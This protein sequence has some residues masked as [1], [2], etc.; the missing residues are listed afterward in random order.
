MA[1]ALA[2]GWG[3]GGAQSPCTP[4]RRGGNCVHEGAPKRKQYAWG[5]L[6]K[7]LLHEQPCLKHSQELGVT[8]RPKRTAARKHPFD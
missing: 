2:G 7:G 8:G 3:A 1:S 6:H 4:E 5:P